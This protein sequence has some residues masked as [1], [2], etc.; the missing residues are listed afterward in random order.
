MLT[1]KRE[2][3]KG[4]A[5]VIGFMLLLAILFL[6][7]SQYQLNVVP[8]EER[9]AEIDHF[10][11]ATEDMSGLRSS[12]IQTA[13]TGQIHTQ[14][15]QL[16]T[17]YNILGLSQSAS[18]G[19]LTYIG[20]RGDIIIDN[21]T[22]NKEASNFWRGDTTREYE[23]G[24]FQYSVDY[25]RITSHADVYIEHGLMY[26]D[27]ARGSDEVVNMLQDSDQPIVKDRSITLYTIQSNIGTS[28][29]GSVTV[30]TNPTSAPMNSVSMTNVEEDSP[31]TIELPTRMSAEDW[32]DIL[33]GEFTS[34]DGYITEIQ[35]TGS[36]SIII[37]FEEGETYNLRMSRV[38][39]STQD[40]RTSTPFTEEQYIA[41]DRETANVRED[42]NIQ[43]DAEVRDKYNNGVI[44]VEVDVEA[45]D[46]NQQCVGDFTGTTTTS[47]NTNCNNDEDYRQ[48]GIDI[49][50]S[51]GSVTY[52]YNAPEIETDR[53]VTFIYRMDSE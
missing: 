14:E 27:N 2:S 35:S 50:S 8:V 15:M 22:N 10:Q 41:V 39:L 16:G 18:R 36:E 25:N 28:R 31:V 37:K 51:D 32:R 5:P 11:E 30:E 42:S 46:S 47:E 44:G 29:A 21:A 52:E 45:Q 19:T 4:V 49:S 48:P 7:A 38:D 13:S 24:F 23:T 6:A 33:E 43:L 40:Q 9:S 3:T 12:I 53:D 1:K 34:N 17:G 26:R 20:G